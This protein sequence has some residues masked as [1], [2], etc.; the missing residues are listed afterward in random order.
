[1]RTLIDQ[2]RPRFVALDFSGVFDLEYTALKMLTDGERRL[3]D[4]GVTLLFVGMNPTVLAMM[5][6]SPLAE[7]SRTRMFF[8]LE[9]AVA[10]YQTSQ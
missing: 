9:Q 10:N 1:M 8:N 4:E 6:H 5:M 2:A 7:L 3:R